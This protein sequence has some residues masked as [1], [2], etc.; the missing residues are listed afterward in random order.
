MIF[1]YANTYMDCSVTLNTLVQS[2]SF[3][4]NL[5][6]TNLPWALK[7]LRALNYHSPGN[8]GDPLKYATSRQIKI[9]ILKYKK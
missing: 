9:W 4:E 7:A 5:K 1:E 2:F 8:T 3:E 6:N